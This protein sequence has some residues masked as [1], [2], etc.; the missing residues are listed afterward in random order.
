[1]YKEITIDTKQL[2]NSI[3]EFSSFGKTEKNGVTR[4]A[5]SRADVEVRE[6]FRKVCES[7]GMV[8]TYDDIGN[9]YGTLAGKNNDIPPIVMG[10]HLDTVEK[11]GKF[12]GSIGIIIGIEVVRALVKNNITPEMP[13]TVV[14]FTNEEGARFEPAMMSSGILAGQFDKDEMFTSSD[15]KGV[16]FK[17][18]LKKSGFQ[19]MISNRLN[20]ATA[21]IELHIEQG[22][23]LETES[24]Q[25]GIVDGVVGMVNYEIEVMGES[26]H[27]GTTPMHLRK[28]AL[29]TTI[30]LIK[31][32]RT[33]LDELYNQILYT[34]ERMNITPNIHT[35]IPNKVVFTIE[36][37]HKDENV[38]NKVESILNLLDIELNDIKIKKQWG[39]NTVDFNEE[40]VNKIEVIT[41][42]LEYSYKKITSGA[43]HDA[44]FISTYIP[45]AMIFIP[46]VNGI[47]HSEKELTLEKDCIAGANVLLQ[48]VLDIV[49]N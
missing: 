30:D 41:K 2:L 46:S 44:Q 6:H 43:G 26:N 42:R 48:T 29:F 15:S 13:I 7:I 35:V 45:T 4:L 32:L 18:A 8:L 14:N 33:N 10:S 40:I 28:D 37:R 23:V 34:I 1:M 3:E 17:D 19:G 21:F 24:L 27:A 38:I 16:T 49:V 20:K 11:G 31:K 9:M 25:I 36:A 22:P 12:D 47:S 39:R 5:L